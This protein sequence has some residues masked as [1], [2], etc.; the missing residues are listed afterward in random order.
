MFLYK[1]VK[2]YTFNIPPLMLFWQI[3]PHIYS[4]ACSQYYIY[5]ATCSQYYITIVICWNICSFYSYLR[6]WQETQREATNVP[7]G[8]RRVQQRCVCTCRSVEL[9]GDIYMSLWWCIVLLHNNY[10][11]SQKKIG[12][13]YST[14]NISWKEFLNLGSIFLLQVF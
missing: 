10:I 14:F 7:W 12:L 4:A 5:R 13:W 1:I 9:E 2:Y 3:T 6:S 11:H 8:W